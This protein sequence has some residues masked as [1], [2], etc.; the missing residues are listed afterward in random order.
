MPSS[1]IQYIPLGNAFQYNAQAEKSRIHTISP[2]IEGLPNPLLMDHYHPCF[3]RR[4]G[5]TMEDVCTTEGKIT[6]TTEFS[7][8][9]TTS[10]K[11][12]T[13]NITSRIGKL[14]QHL[15]ILQT[16]HTHSNPTTEERTFLQW[17]VTNAPKEASYPS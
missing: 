10:S 7:T 4:F 11:L 13:L 6:T 17:H 12:S 16:S 5:K 8:K 14:Q 1:S 2:S 3:I 9:E 15:Y